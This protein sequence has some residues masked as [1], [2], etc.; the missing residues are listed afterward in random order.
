MWYKLQKEEKKC[1]KGTGRD[2]WNG[3]IFNTGTKLEDGLHLLYT[4]SY[5]SINRCIHDGTRYFISSN[6]RLHV[7]HVGGMAQ[8][9]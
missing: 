3:G 8:S 4:F 7:G 6:S 2:V 1:R 5:K 9:M